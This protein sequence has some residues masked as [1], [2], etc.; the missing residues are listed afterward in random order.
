MDFISV[1]LIAI[2]LS[3]DS[4]AVSVSNGLSVKDLKFSKAVVIAFFLA[5]F[6]TLMPFLGWFIGLSVEHL[7]KEFDHWIAFTLLGLIGAKMIYE[8]LSK[9]EKEKPTQL[10]YLIIIAQSIATSIDA[11]VVGVSLAFLGIPIM[12]PLV[13]IGV[14]TFLFSMIGMKLGIFIGKQFGKSIEVFGGLILVGIGT[15]I[16]FDHLGYLP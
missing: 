12:K 16:L 1:L 4:F 15:K 3:M 11:F 10:T 6:Q 7:I 14:V 5:F 8:G 9:D 13:I 2:G